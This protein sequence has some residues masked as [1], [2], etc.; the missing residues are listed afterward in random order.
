MKI[1]VFSDY[2][3]ECMSKFV[4]KYPMINPNVLYIGKKQLTEFK[5]EFNIQEIHGLCRIHGMRLVLVDD[6]FYLNCGVEL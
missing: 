5:I 6:Y 1:D 4:E 3:Y 2:S